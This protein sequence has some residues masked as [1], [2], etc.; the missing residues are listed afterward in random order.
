[1]TRFQKSGKDGKAETGRK[2][3]RRRTTGK[4]RLG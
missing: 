4:Y 3:Y 2:A 1:M